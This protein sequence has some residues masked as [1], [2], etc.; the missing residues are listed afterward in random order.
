MKD[1]IK[2]IRKQTN[3]TQTEFG[4]KIGVKGNTITGYETGLRNPSDAIINS[5]CREFNVNELWLRT[6]E[7][8]PFNK[9]D[10]ED[11][12]SINLGKLALKEDDL[13]VRNAINYL[14]ECEPEK[15][16]ILEEFM[17]K[18]LGI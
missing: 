11:R 2:S 7:G 10:E 12:Y 4:K 14:A 17:K 8:E 6:G 18:C 9:I 15:L 3:L 1:R 13:F 16:K 5:I